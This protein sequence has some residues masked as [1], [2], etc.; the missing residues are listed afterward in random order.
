MSTT[1]I[2]VAYGAVLA[3]VL[4]FTV[5]FGVA[6]VLPGPTPPGDPGITF[7]QLT[8]EDTDNSQNRLTASIDQ[9]FADAKNFRDDFVSYQRNFFLA[10]AGLAVLLAL[11]A[12]ALPSAV[13]YMRWGMLVGAALIMIWVGHLATMPVPNPAPPA[14][15]VLA[16][17]AAGEPEPLSFAG[18][19]LRF[20]ISFV[21]L[22]LLLFI[23]LWRLTEWPAAPRKTAPAAARPATTTPAPAGDAAAWAPAPAAPVPVTPAAPAA[24]TPPEATTVVSE[25]SPQ[26]ST[27][28]A[29]PSA[30]PPGEAG[31]WQR[32]SDAGEPNRQPDTT[33]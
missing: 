7:R 3:L 8:T 21:S 14:N 19:F 4:F 29:P 6:M 25:P 23:G 28:P 30:S 16:M 5:L 2:R 9:F 15:S 31:R 24:T 12:V 11:I 17:V 22:I 18:R 32:P 26:P 20:A 1:W 13:N 27:Q 10:A 33:V